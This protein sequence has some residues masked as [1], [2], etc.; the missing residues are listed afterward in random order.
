MDAKVEIRSEAGLVWWE[1]SKKSD[2]D[3]LL[4]VIPTIYYRKDNRA[5]PSEPFS[6]SHYYGF[7]LLRT[8]DMRE[9]IEILTKTETFDFAVPVYSDGTYPHGGEAITVYKSE[10]L[11]EGIVDLR[12]VFVAIEHACRD[13]IWEIM[14][15]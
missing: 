13:L 8:G 6:T 10:E 14:E 12:T 11:P 4:Y 7:S 15:V 9:I 1:I 5:W 2:G 3:A